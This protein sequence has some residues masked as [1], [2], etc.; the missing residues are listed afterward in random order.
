MFR[1]SVTTVLAVIALAMVILAPAAS[2]APGA[3]ASPFVGSWTVEQVPPGGGPHTQGTLVLTQNG[4]ELS[5]VLRL[6][7]AQF[8]VSDVDDTGGVLSF[9]V[10]LPGNITLHY[11]GA[12]MN[13]ELGLAS[14]DEGRGSY[15]LTARRAGGATASV[16]GRVAAAP[17]STG[18][19]GPG[20][21]APGGN[22][23]NRLLNQA[24]TSAAP[25][26][27]P[28]PT[29]PPRGAQRAASAPPPP[30]AT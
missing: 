4:N 1:R 27:P 28:V 29:G 16:P 26:A 17:P 14:E 20:V 3:A 10:M 23:I 21:P 30:A 22:F 9:T 2:A 18:P 5:G 8:P 25:P 11:I 7:G 15:T 6:N 12:L 24:P 13:D 19:T